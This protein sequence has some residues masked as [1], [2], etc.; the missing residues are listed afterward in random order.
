[1]A[2]SNYGVVKG[3]FD[4][5][6][7]DPIDNFG[8][9]LH[10]HIFVRAPG[11]DRAQVLF[12]CACD[13]NTPSGWVDY[14]HVPQLDPGKFL[15]VPGLPDGHHF[16]PTA[17]DPSAATGGALDFVR[18]PLISLPLG[19]AA[20]FFGL[21]NSLT[22]KNN[23]V[24][25]KNNG[26]DA[27]NVL[28]PMMES[29]DIDKVYVFGARWDNPAQNPAQGLHD[30]HYNQGDPPGQFQHLDQIWQDGAVIVRHSTGRYEGFFVRFNTQTMNTDDNGLPKP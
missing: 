23:Q 21:L 18:N 27:L 12:D 6:E 13:V 26:E 25:T 24:W 3:D 8:R 9:F 30:V 5:F 20:I 15:V 7:R 22:G 29:T 1:M 11:A 28:Q 16:L 10:G 4:H 14:F 2:L 17:H 19:C